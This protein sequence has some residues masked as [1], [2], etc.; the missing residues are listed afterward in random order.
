[1]EGGGGRLY[2]GHRGERVRGR[3]GC[4]EKKGVV[5]EVLGALREWGGCVW[6]WKV[7]ATLLLWST[8][9]RVCVLRTA[10]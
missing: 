6:M 3:E 10:Q 9:L 7:D 4:E 8:M 2:C 5:G 1:M